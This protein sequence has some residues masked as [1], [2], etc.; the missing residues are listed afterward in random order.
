MNLEQQQKL[1]E[2]L[3]KAQSLTDKLYGTKAGLLVQG[4]NLNYWGLL[5]VLAYVQAPIPGWGWVALVGI[6]A[7]LSWLSPA[8]QDAIDPRQRQPG[9]QDETTES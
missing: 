4:L 5:G 6:G 3:D 8:P 2:M 1:V 9:N 7:V